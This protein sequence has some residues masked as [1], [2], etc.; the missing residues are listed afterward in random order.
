MLGAGPG[1]YQYEGVG[2]EQHNLDDVA[3]SAQAADLLGD[4]VHGG[5]RTFQRPHAGSVAARPVLVSAAAPRRVLTLCFLS[6]RPGA[7]RPPS[8]GTRASASTVGRAVTPL[9]QASITS[10]HVGDA[11]SSCGPPVRVPPSLAQ[12]TRRA[13]YLRANAAA[14]TVRGLK[15]AEERRRAAVESVRR[16]L[17]VIV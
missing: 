3:S 15:G 8:P 12:R 14:A 11:A 9:R 16:K 4:R 10:G 1:A 17:L 2:H 5:R 6:M 7:W 13:A